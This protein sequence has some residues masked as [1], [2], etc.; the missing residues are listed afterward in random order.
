[1]K[2]EDDRFLGFLWFLSVIERVLFVAGAAGFAWL[3]LYLF[4]S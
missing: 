4:G 2:T 3:M 1:M